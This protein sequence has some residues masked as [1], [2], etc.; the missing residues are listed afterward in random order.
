M[1]VDEVVDEYRRKHWGDLMNMARR[2]ARQRSERMHVVALPWSYRG[3]SGWHYVIMS[4]ASA[5]RSRAG[6]GN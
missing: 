4:A 2:H 1:I 6:R 3:R 5:D